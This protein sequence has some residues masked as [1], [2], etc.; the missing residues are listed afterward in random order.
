MPGGPS[1]PLVIGHELGHRLGRPVFR[2][3]LDDS[4]PDPSGVACAGDVVVVDGW[5]AY[6]AAVSCLGRPTSSIVAVIT[7]GEDA[8][9]LVARPICRVVP[10]GSALS[11]PSS[12][13]G[14]GHHIE[15]ALPADPF[16][17]CRHTRIGSDRRWGVIGAVTLPTVDRLRLL[18]ADAP[19]GE[20]T[21]LARW[22]D[23]LILEHPH[24]DNP[25]VAVHA[26][27]SEAVVLTGGPLGTDTL[28]RSPAVTIVDDWSTAVAT[29][30]ALDP[31]A[32]C[33]RLQ[34]TAEQVAADVGRRLVGVIAPTEE[35]VP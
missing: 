5:A 26:A 34:H 13:S 24:I 30:E 33:R 12:A 10:A 14:V 20:K 18:P 6:R 35:V 16:P 23:V 7:G 29:A 21:A 11:L 9:I 32:G 31:V 3:V 22:A 17:W 25:A 27:I 19:L 8:R 28:A 2:Q 4:H 15:L 1:L